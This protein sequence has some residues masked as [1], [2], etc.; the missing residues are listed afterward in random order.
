MLT[1][2]KVSVVVV[3]VKAVVGGC[4]GSANASCGEKERERSGEKAFFHYKIPN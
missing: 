2:C 1:S 4:A 3:V